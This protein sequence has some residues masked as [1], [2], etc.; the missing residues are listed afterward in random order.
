[1][2]LPEPYFETELGKLYCGDCLEIMPGLES[3]DLVLTDP[4]YGIERFKRAKCSLRFDKSNKYP[5]GLMFGGKPSKKAFDIIFKISKNAIIWGANNFTLPESEYFFV[6]DKSQTVDNFASAEL[7]FTNIKQ[8]AKVFSYSIHQHNKS[9]KYHPTQKP[10]GLMEWCIGFANGAKTIL[11]PYLGSG[12]TAV[13]CERL[14]RRWI[15][16]E[17]SEEYCE[18]SKRRIIKERQQL[19]LF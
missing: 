13:A 3:V 4:D 7:A 16:I 9:T 14:N 6:W 18:I 1:M 17:I 5:N 8:P 19:K 15:G 2:T 10:I 11:D 12:T